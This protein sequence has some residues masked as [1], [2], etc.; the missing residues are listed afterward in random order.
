M[1]LEGFADLDRELQRLGKATTQKASLRRASKK[2]LQPMAEIARGLAPRGVDGE[3]APS[4][5]VSTKLTKRQK[6]Q[7]RKM[8]R[9]DKA[10]VEMF[11]GPGPDPAAWNQEFG[12]RNHLAQP[13]MRP[14]WDQDHKAMLD[15]LKAELWAD[16]QK[17]LA[18][19]ERRAARQAARG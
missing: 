3:L 16:I 19:A 14:A 18:R 13:Y 8:F 6:G 12:N 17:T 11:M 4:I 15:R 1:K 2:A 9:N 5:T 7:H 10:A